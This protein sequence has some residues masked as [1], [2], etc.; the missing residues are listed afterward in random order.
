MANS[1]KYYAH[2]KLLLTGEYAVLDGAIALAFPTRK[3]QWLKASQG[4]PDIIQWISKDENQNVWFNASFSSSLKIVSTSDEEIAERLQKIL[5]QAIELNSE[6]AIELIGKYV[7]TTLE[8]NMN[9]G[10]GSSSTLI[11]LISQWA[12]V[13]QYS[14]LKKSFG[15]SGYDLACAQAVGPIL[16]QNRNGGPKVV[17]I[18]FNPNWQD[19]L[20]FVYL[21][22]KQISRTEIT[23]FNTLEIDRDWLVNEVDSLTKKVAESTTVENFSDAL[24]DHE[25]LLSATLGYPTIKSQLFSN[26]DGVF[27][28]LGAWGGD[29]VLFVGKKTELEK[30]RK[31]GFKTIIPWKEMVNPILY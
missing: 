7:T 8:F 30:V 18:R 17:P 3:G 9:W 19:K 25:K 12:E 4:S 28:S 31:M 20:Y 23:K 6:F 15:G 14:L 27:K 2:G 29:F 24:M 11:N 5:A 16:F 13:D 10:L 26:I 21:G 22:K 1:K